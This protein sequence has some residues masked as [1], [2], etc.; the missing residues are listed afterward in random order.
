MDND[1]N[2]YPISVSYKGRVTLC[3]GD[4]SEEYLETSAGLR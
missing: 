1:M 4:G 2:D 3:P